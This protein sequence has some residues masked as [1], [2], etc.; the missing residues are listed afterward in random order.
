LLT[1]AGLW[2]K[3]RTVV[4]ANALGDEADTLEF[5][6]LTDAGLWKKL[7]TVVAANASW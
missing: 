1:D 7:R 6:L 3:L 4:A 2:K 5:E